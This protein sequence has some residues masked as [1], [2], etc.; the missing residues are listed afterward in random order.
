MKFKLDENIPLQLK[1]IIKTAGY[2][3][4]DVYQQD[5][6]GKTDVL[7]LE[8]C[9][10]EG[11]ILITNDSDFEN[12]YAY[13]S[14]KHV[15]I[16]VFKLKSQGAKS[17]IAAFKLLLEK[18]NVSEIKNVITLVGNDSIKIRR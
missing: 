16:I 8:K 3:A 6:S 13:P 2:V 14:E 5:L 7:V 1:Q 17:V 12:I 10:K 4:C 18:V 9:R 11:Y 15:G